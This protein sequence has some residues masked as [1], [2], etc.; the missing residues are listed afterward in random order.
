MFP[1]LLKTKFHI[2]QTSPNLIQRPR[3]IQLV[4]EGLQYPILLI[5]ATAGFGKTTLVSQWRNTPAGEKFPLAW[6]S[7]D[8][9]DNDPI[10]F[11][12][13]VTEALEHIAPEIS[14]EIKGL[15]LALQLS[16]PKAMLTALLNALSSVNNPF[17]LVLDDYH[18][19]TT[20]LIHEVMTFLLH[21]LPMHMHV[22]LISRSD[23]P[24][25]LGQLRAHGKVF[26]IRTDDLRFI[27]AQIAEFLQVGNLSQSSAV[28]EALEARTEGWIAG[29]KLAE[30]AMRTNRDVE[31]F[32]HSL[33]I[34]NRYI[35]DYLIDGVLNQLPPMLQRFLL[36]TSILSRVNGALGSAAHLRSNQ[37]SATL[38][39]GFR[40]PAHRL[41]TTFF[42]HPNSI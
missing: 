38:A 33:T 17:A 24:L 21:R 23:P 30:L 26:E 15:L 25:L 3:L 6:L 22:I 27:S 32:I 7:L 11:L 36:E 41:W 10:H 18:C 29:L 39:T 12:T 19:I 16:S 8:D 9:D 37:P 28:L 34:S 20:P 40:I 13:Y 35:L 42:L 5:S 14:E 2:P 4:D 31:Q 1:A